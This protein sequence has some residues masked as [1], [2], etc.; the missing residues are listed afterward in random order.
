MRSRT[1]SSAMTSKASS[2]NSLRHGILKTTGKKSATP[3]YKYTVKDMIKTITKRKFASD[4]SSSK[5]TTID[6]Q[7]PITSS[8]PDKTIV[9]DASKKTNLSAPTSTSTHPATKRNLFGIKLNHD[10]L[11][12]DLKEMWKEQIER[13]KVQWN[14]DFEKLKPVDP[15]IQHQDQPEKIS[16]RRTRSSSL[17]EKQL[18]LQSNEN[19]LSEDREDKRYEWKKVNTYYE[20]VIRPRTMINSSSNLQTPLRPT[21][22]LNPLNS[23]PNRYG[24]SISA[25]HHDEID[26]NENN[27]AYDDESS[28]E[29][30]YD[31]ALAVPQFYKYQRILKPND[32]NRPKLNTSTSSSSEY[33]LYQNKATNT[34]PSSSQ[35]MLKMEPI[36]RMQK[37]GEEAAKSSE[38]K[39]SAVVKA[40]RIVKRCRASRNGKVV[41]SSENSSM[42]KESINQLIITLS[43]NRKDTLRSANQSSAN[44]S[45]AKMVSSECSG[46][47]AHTGAK[48]KQQSI[49]DLFQQRKRKRSGS[50]Q[51]EK[52]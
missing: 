22:M 31:E 10:Q 39:S 46:N 30:E 19:E 16:R 44:T 41:K 50:S 13:Q 14:F 21:N 28:E 40:R 34:S 48:L 47:G 35:Q 20:P 26:H 18:A 2:S 24:L 52:F 1:K 42:M 33:L 43:E 6:I 45:P 12:R 37:G 23:T 5:K 4:D 17:S 11:N 9:S 36:F 15:E 3:T 49:L 7:E 38:A 32:K 25:F 29:E 51:C 8:F 27:F